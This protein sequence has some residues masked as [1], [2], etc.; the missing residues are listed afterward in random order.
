[1]AEACGGTCNKLW[2][3]LFKQRFLVPKAETSFA[4]TTRFADWPTSSVLPL[5]SGGVAR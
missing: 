1:M 5:P 4:P 3:Q 2:N